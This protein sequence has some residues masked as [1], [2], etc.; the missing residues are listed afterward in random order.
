MR[1][2]PAAEQARA[3]A[4]DDFGACYA[5]AREL[6]ELG[7]KGVQTRA[8][9]HGEVSR[10]AV[11]A[12]LACNEIV[13]SQEPPARLGRIRDSSRPLTDTEKKAYEEMGTSITRRP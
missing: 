2:Q 5:V 4:T 12:V 13:M 9:V 1:L 6:R 7:Q 11:L 8:Y 10:H 3:D